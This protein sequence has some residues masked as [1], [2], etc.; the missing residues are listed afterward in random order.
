[1]KFLKG[2]A[3]ALLG[4]LLFLSLSIFGFAFQLNDTVL[5]PDFVVTEL[6]KLDVSLLA[7]EVLNILHRDLSS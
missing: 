1:M 7:K 2:L 6:D 4:F 5:K 3:L